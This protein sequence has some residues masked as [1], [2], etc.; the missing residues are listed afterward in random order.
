MW[1]ARTFSPNLNKFGIPRQIFMKVP[2]TKF[3]G[4]QSSG[5]RAD[6]CGR[7][8][9]DMTKVM[10]ASSAYTKAPKN[11]SFFSQSVF[12]SF[13]RLSV[14]IAIQRQPTG[15]CNGETADL[16]HFW[17]PRKNK[18]EGPTCKYSYID[19]AERAYIYTYKIC[20]IQNLKYNESFRTPSPPQRGAAMQSHK[21]R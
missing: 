13:E 4:N 12:M 15:L 8:Q 5:S 10:G 11:S 16:R 3:H 14:Q 21:L 2:N 1:S 18:F 9:T 7:W 6:T 17:A 19:N 20:L